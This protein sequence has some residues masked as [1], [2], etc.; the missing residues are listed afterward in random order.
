MIK[1]QKNENTKEEDSNKENPPDIEKNDNNVEGGKPL[2]PGE[3]VKEQNV[4]NQPQ[5]QKKSGLSSLLDGNLV[6]LDS[7]GPKRSNRNNNDFNN[8]W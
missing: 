2:E 5:E 1:G 3:E 6:N 8:Y 4:N 7:L